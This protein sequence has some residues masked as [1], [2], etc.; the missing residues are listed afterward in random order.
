MSNSKVK[1]TLNTLTHQ[2]TALFSQ[3]MQH[4]CQLNFRSL[5]CLCTLQ[6]HPQPMAFSWGLATV[7]QIVA[8]ASN[9]IWC[10]SQAVDFFRRH[11]ITLM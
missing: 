2:R 7:V 10:M 6:S 1:H 8:E 5:I 4:H 11:Q 9:I 3:G